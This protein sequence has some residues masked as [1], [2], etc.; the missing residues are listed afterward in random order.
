MAKMLDGVRA[1]PSTGPALTI[2]AGLTAFA[3]IVSLA[4]WYVALP[5]SLVSVLVAVL[6]LKNGSRFA[7][8]AAVVAG[9][10]LVG[11]VSVG[12]LLAPA[13]TTRTLTVTNS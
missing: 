3:A 13:H 6:A 8:V 9:V 1:E 11:S 5:I 12:V 7:R 10:A 4:V 2:V